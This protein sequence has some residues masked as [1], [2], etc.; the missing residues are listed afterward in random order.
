MKDA[1]TVPYFN[2]AISFLVVDVEGCS[3]TSFVVFLSS[4]KD[5]FYHLTL[6]HISTY[7]IFFW[8]WF[9]H[10]CGHVDMYSIVFNIYLLKHS[11]WSVPTI[12]YCAW[13]GDWMEVYISASRQERN[14]DFKLKYWFCTNT[15]VDETQY[16]LY[17]GVHVHIMLLSF[18]WLHEHILS[19]V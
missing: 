6:F 11:E 16:I 4:M 2:I 15:I 14:W 17:S 10:W 12:L 9:N 5:A 3:H 1:H 19:L 18:I 7:L 8:Q 13:C